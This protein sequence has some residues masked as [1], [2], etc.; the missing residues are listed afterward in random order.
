M[1]K[2]H[3]IKMDTTWIWFSGWKR[4]QVGSLYLNT[5]DQKIIRGQRR[6]ICQSRLVVLFFDTPISIS[7]TTPKYG[8]GRRKI[9]SNFGCAG[10]ASDKDTRCKVSR[11]TATTLT[12][13][14]PELERGWWKWKMVT[15]CKLHHSLTLIVLDAISSLCD[16][17]GDCLM[18]N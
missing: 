15:V 13:R 11:V 6:R 4:P 3:K 5:L 2:N 10:G 14:T 17:S 12:H 16:W 18:C 1:W 9:Y 8:P 7:A